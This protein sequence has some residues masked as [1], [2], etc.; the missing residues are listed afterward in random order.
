MIPTH[1]SEILLN[2][3][4]YYIDQE[5]SPILVLDPTLE[6]GQA[7][8]KDRLAPMIRD[9]PALQGKIKNPRA[10]DNGNTLLHKTFLGG[11]ITIAGANSPASLASRPIRMQRDR[12][13]VV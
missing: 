4:G 1:N 3:I 13:S 8:S 10:R 11:H 2:I 5:P 6:M 9:T 7:F 12:K